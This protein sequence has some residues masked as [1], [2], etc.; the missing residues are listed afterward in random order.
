MT[1]ELRPYGDKCNLR[2]E[3]CYENPLRD[4]N[5]PKGKPDYEEIKRVLKKHDKH[6]TVFGGDPLVIPLEEL[7]DLWI[8]GMVN[9]GQN[10][11][12]TNGSL[13]TETHIALFKQYNVH[14]GFSID[15]PHMLNDARSAPSGNL[16][17]TRALTDKS[18][19]N[20]VTCLQKGIGTSLICTLTKMNASSE[21]IDT[22]IKWFEYLNK[23][24]LKSVRLHFMENN[25]ANHLQLS[26]E[27][28]VVALK[29]FYRLHENTNLD[30]DIFKEM[31]SK[32]RG[33]DGG[34]CIY[35]GCDPMNTQA[36]DGLDHNGEPTNC[37]RT[38]KEGI[39]FLKAEPRLRMRDWIL[40]TTPQ[41][42]N[43]CK[44][45][46]YWYACHGNCSGSGI[47]GDWR[48]RST[49]CEV[50]RFLFQYI[51]EKK[52]ITLLSPEEKIETLPFCGHGDREHGDK[53]GDHSDNRPHG[54][55][56]D[57]RV[58]LPR[59]EVRR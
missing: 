12:Q 24:G 41:K 50:L 25:N 15:G 37:G 6:F 22:L 11:I 30:F 26:Y 55:H 9:W 17:A 53:H 54:D 58:E 35:N 5:L 32:L 57:G 34:C 45:C 27:D 16:D 48:N 56:T 39:D 1:V 44:G 10:G 18:N 49:H 33:G 40:S 42:D 19:Q 31:E 20:M 43:G 8:F 23:K 46:E 51:L 21:R 14:V 7:E 13:I 59:L 38:N 36:V 52:D 3:Y 2:C 28:T 4:Y 47:D 29:R